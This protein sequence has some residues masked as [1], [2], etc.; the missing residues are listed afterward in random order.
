MKTE[1]KSDNELIAEFM[2]ICVT[3]SF[4]VLWIVDEDGD[5]PDYKNAQVYSPSNNW[6]QL[7][8]VVGQFIE[9]AKGTDMPHALYMNVATFSVSRP[10]GE[11]YENLVKGIRWYNE[12]ST[13][14]P[15][16]S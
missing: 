7:I 8:P 15:E 1:V 14:N 2:G 9:K 3:R 10:I 5:L 13:S 6:N 16:Q 11:L 12:H 4:D